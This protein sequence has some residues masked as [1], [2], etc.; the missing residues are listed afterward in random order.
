M[1]SFVQIV[2]SMHGLLAYLCATLCMHYYVYYHY[3]YYYNNYY[4]YITCS[5]ILTRVRIT[6]VDILITVNPCPTS[7]TGTSVRCYV[8]L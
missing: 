1:Y 7:F 8:I 4:T 5:F 3:Y 2:V 6:V